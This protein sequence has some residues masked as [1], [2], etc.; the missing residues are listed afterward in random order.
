MQSMPNHISELS[1]E[2]LSEKDGKYIG[3]AVGAGLVLVVIPCVA[4][5]FGIEKIA[6]SPAVGLPILA[7]L[8]IMML[9]GALA[10][11]STLF[12]RLKLHDP[13]Q[14]LALPEGSIRAA[15]LTYWGLA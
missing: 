7:I 9:F 2:P 12:A 13:S 10:L 3:G 8:G 6:A 1:K 4:L 15:I 5:Y 11:I 14:P